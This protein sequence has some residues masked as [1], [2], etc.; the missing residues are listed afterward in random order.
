M[1]WILSIIGPLLISLIVT[2]LFNKLVGLPK[3]LKESKEAER[4]QQETLMKKVEEQEVQIE[5]LKQEQKSKDIL[6]KVLKT[7]SDCAEAYYY[8]ALYDK[9]REIPYLKKSLAI[10]ITY[11]DAW[12]DIARVEIERQNLRLAKKYLAI[13]KYIDENDFRYYYYQGVISKS[14]GFDG[15]AKSNF[16]KSLMLNPDFDLAKEEL[17]I[18]KQTF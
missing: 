6:S 18:W 14:E 17:S 1:E 5:A 10:N 2:L 12:I 16:Q 4:K 8:M 13:A 7:H 9:D 11:K 3:K 15:D